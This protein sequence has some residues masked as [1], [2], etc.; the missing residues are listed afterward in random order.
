MVIMTTPS[1]GGTA[2]RVWGVLDLSVLT[3]DLVSS[4][5]YLWRETE[6]S[7]LGLLTASSEKQKQLP[8]LLI[9]PPQ[10]RRRKG[11][12]G[13]RVKH[14]PPDDQATA[15]SLSNTAASKTLSTPLAK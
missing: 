5:V 13:L 7:G 10:T 14:W 9:H 4:E 15:D 12:Y 11:G 2:E 6:E 8:G 1:P 3:F